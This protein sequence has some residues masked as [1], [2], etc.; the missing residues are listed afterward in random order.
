MLSRQVTRLFLSKG[1]SVIRAGKPVRLCFSTLVEQKGLGEE[2]RFIR[3]QEIKRKEEM[4]ANLDRIL[5]RND[6]DDEKAKLLEIL[7][8]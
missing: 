4:K 8:M 2:A 3:E 6:D 1:A 5:S 7:G